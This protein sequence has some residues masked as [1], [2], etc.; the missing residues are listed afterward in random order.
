MKRKILIR[1][2]ITSLLLSYLLIK[3]DINTIYYIFIEMNIILLALTAPLIGIMYAIR[4]KKWQI[5]LG[6]VD[7]A[8][9]FWNAYKIVLVSTFY[10]ALTPGRVGEL[11]RSFYLKEKKAKT[12]PTIMVDRMVDIF[13]LLLLSVLFVFIFF[14]DNNL[15][16]LI[17]LLIILFIAGTIIITN[18]KIIS[19]LFWIFRQSGEVKKDYIISIKSIM[20]NRRAL[21]SVFIFS[22]SYYMVNLCV[23]WLI[24]KAINPML[25]DLIVFSLPIIV[26]LSN[27][28]ISISG[29][30]VREFVSVA[31]FNMLNESSAYGFSF[32]LMLYILTILMPGIVGIL[33]YHIA[34]TVVTFKTGN[35]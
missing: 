3:I 34:K 35:R 26:L 28:P 2:I 1:V 32:S 22:L 16:T 31:I 8:I 30:G 7:V 21:F 29:L 13:C 27:I 20:G 33:W 24:L 5:L 11:S 17:G 12:M 10:G 4:T 6:S 14:Y 18:E 25:N 15:I 9:P 23:Y 19:F